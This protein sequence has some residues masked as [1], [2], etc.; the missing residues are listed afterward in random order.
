MQ[1]HGPPV[2]AEAWKRP[3]RRPGTCPRSR[4]WRR[5][6]WSR[7]FATAGRMPESE[8]YGVASTRNSDREPMWFGRF[9]RTESERTGQQGLYGNRCSHSSTREA[10]RRAQS[11]A[12]WTA[13]TD[14]LESRRLLNGAQCCQSGW[15]GAFARLRSKRSVDGMLRDWISWYRSQMGFWRW[16]QD[17]AQVLRL[18]SPYHE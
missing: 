2:G 7:A 1:R 12:R 9:F 17:E 6:R 18:G 10:Q 13:A 3:S 14:S 11:P 16:P 15:N 8:Q 4:P 5:R